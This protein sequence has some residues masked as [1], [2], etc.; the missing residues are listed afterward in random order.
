MRI[1][2]TIPVSMEGIAGYMLDHTPAAAP[3][4]IL[5]ISVKMKVIFSKFHSKLNII[6]YSLYYGIIV[7]IITP[8]DTQY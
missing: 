8:L 1:V 6:M 3:T 2:I 7:I 5:D 4:H